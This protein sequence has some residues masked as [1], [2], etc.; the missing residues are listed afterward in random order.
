MNDTSKQLILIALQQSGIEG[1]EAA[2]LLVNLGA[3]EEWVGARDAAKEFGISHTALF[4]WLNNGVMKTTGIPFPESVR[5]RETP[6]GTIQYERGSIRRWAASQTKAGPSKGARFNSRWQKRK[7][8]AAC[9][10]K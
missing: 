2:K 10:P 9:E 6:A 7:E 8:A 4:R 3:E 1:D 5:W